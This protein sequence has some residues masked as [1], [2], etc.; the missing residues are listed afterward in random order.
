MV[1]N[2]ALPSSLGLDVFPKSNYSNYMQAK[3]VRIGNSRGL[4]IPQALL[5]LYH[6]REG[7]NVELEARRDGILLKPIPEKS[8]KLGW[9]EA[10]GQ[11]AEEAAERAEWSEWDAVAEDGIED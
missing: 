6:V 7:E 3:L 11:M 2:N 5:E 9:E 10:Y 8:G 1:F 4:R